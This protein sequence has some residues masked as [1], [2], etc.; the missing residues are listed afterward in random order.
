M[1]PNSNSGY[2]SGRQV[3]DYSLNGYGSPYGSQGS[4][5]PPPHYYALP[6]QAPTGTRQQGPSP[7][8][9]SSYVPPSPATY[10][11]SHA[12]PGARP[13][14]TEAYPTF[15][16]RHSYTESYPAFPDRP[17]SYTESYSAFPGRPGSGN[18]ASRGSHTDTGSYA[19]RS[20]L[21]STFTPEKSA[22]HPSPDV[23][24][25]ADASQP[26][27]YGH[28]WQSD[29]SRGD[30][31]PP[32]GGSGYLRTEYASSPGKE[33]VPARGSGPP[34]DSDATIAIPVSNFVSE[35][36][37]RCRASIDLI[38]TLCRKWFVI[39]VVGSHRF[40]GNSRLESNCPCP[41]HSRHLGY[42]CHYWCRSYCL[43]GD[44]RPTTKRR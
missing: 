30:P 10:G 2:G 17:G 40:T 24:L 15:P 41:N 34:A 28:Q 25:Y 37:L 1:N 11:N 14:Y 12:I 27:G 38:C 9:V 20:A 21:S 36:F 3:P 13:S 32:T 43:Q 19:R 42:G 4:D 16:G 22:Y 35:L 26:P 33:P 44:H 7:S 39:F 5:H 8:G 6:G 31:P 23:G 29:P 18:S